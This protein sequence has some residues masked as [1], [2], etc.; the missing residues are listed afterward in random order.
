MGRSIFFTLSSLILSTILLSG[1]SS[2]GPRPL[3]YSDDGPLTPL[4]DEFL[5]QDPEDQVLDSAVQDYLKLTKAP[6]SSR[7]DFTRVDLDGDHR[8]D[9][10]VMMEG[11]HGYWCAANGCSL[12]VFRAAD[13][14]FEWSSNIFPVRGPLYVSNT[15][16]EGWKNL[17]IRVTGQPDVKA[18]DVAMQFDGRRYPSNPLTQPSVR[19]SQ[20][21]HGQR[22]FP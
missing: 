18:K 11:P 4:P 21:D 9:A 1:C 6:L 7:Y 2:S 17:I 13:D 5:P 3:S 12:I 8:R 15:T 19:V 16:S 10:L 20:D 14:H 22:L